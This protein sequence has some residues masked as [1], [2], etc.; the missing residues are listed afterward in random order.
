MVY[1][2]GL[3]NS[4]QDLFANTTR[5]I[6]EFVAREYEN[7][8]DFRLGIIEM[9]LPALATPTAPADKNDLLEMEL[10]KNAVKEYSAETNHRKRLQKRVFPLILGQCS[11][12][13]RDRLEA[14]KTWAKLNADSD[15]FGL[16]ALIRSS[17]NQRATNRNALHTYVDAEFELISFRQTDNMSVSDYKLKL[18]SLVEIYES[19]GGEPGCSDARL[20]AHLPTR[21][22]GAYDLDQATDAELA[23]AKTSAR[24][25]Y[26]AMLLI[27]RSDSR[28]FGRLVADMHNAHL[29]GDHSSYPTSLDQAFD[30]LVNY[31]P[32][33]QPRHHRH[34]ESGLTFGQFDDSPDDDRKPPPRGPGRGP[35]GRGNGGRGGRNPGRGRGG[36]GRGQDEHHNHAVDNT[37]VESDSYSP[38]PPVVRS[39]DSEAEVNLAA[40]SAGRLPD[41]WLLLDSCSSV[42]LVVNPDLLTNL[43]RPGNTILV[44]CNAGAVTLD[45]QGF[46]GSYPFPV[47]YH[48]TGV[49]NIVS[50]NNV[51]KHFRVRMDNDIGNYFEL[52][53]K[54]G[55]T[56]RFEPSGKGLYHHDFGDDEN[57][58]T[59]WTMISTVEEQA[60]KYTRRALNNAA[61]ARRFQNI[62]M[63]P[64]TKMLGD[65]GIPHLRNCPI[66][67]ADLQAA[68]DIFGPNLGSLK[69]KTVRRPT[70]HVK[71]G[72][73]PVPREILALYKHVEIG[74]DIMFVNKIPF[75]LTISRGLK[76]GTVDVLSNRQVST[77]A[78][79]LKAVDRTYRRRG[80]R[81]SIFRAD[82]EFE[83]LKP[84]IPE[85]ETCGQDDHV[86]EVERF[87]RTVKDRAR[88]TYRMLPFAYV[89][90]IVLIHL[91]RNCVFWINAFPQG[92]GAAQRYSPR[93]IMTGWD[94]DYVNHVREEFGGYVQTH[95]DHNNSMN[96][97]TTGAI[98]LGPCG[99]KQGAHW[100]MSLATGQRIRRSRWTALPMPTDVVNRVSEL[101]RAQN[102][103][104]T[105]TFADRHGK[106][107][108]D[109]LD[110]LSTASDFDDDDYSVSTDSSD[111]TDDISFAPS[112]EEVT[113][114]F[115]P[116]NTS[117]DPAVAADNNRLRLFVENVENVLGDES[118]S[119]DQDSD[120]ESIS[121]SPDAAIGQSRDPPPSHRTRA[122]SAAHEAAL[123]RR[124]SR[125]AAR[126]IFSDVDDVFPDPVESAGVW[127]DQST[128]IPGVVDDAPSMEI[129]GVADKA[130]D[131]SNEE[132]DAEEDEH[133]TDEY[134]PES[135][136]VGDNPDDDVKA[137]DEASLD[138]EGFEKEFES[139][140]DEYNRIIEESKQSAVSSPSANR[141]RRSRKKR[142]NKK[143]SEE[144]FVHI[145]FEDFNHHAL[146]QTITK[147][148]PEHMIT[149][150][151]EQMTAQKGIKLF[152][153]RGEKAIM[154]ELEQLLYRKVMEGRHANTLTWAQKKAALKYL[155]F[156]KEKRCGKIKGRG[157][158]D[159]RKQRLY[160]TKDETSSPTV[161]IESLFLTSMVDARERRKVI[162]VDIPG[163]FMQADVDELIHVKLE[164]DVALLLIKI[165]PTYQQFL[166]YE[167]NRPV[168]YA[169]L[170]KAL[171]GTVQAAYLFWQNLTSFLVDKLGFKVNP[172]DP[173]VANKVVDGAQCTVVWHV[174]DL[175]VSHRDQSVLEWFIDELNRE[176][177]KEAEVTV[178]RGSTHDYLGMTITFND[179]GS[180][181][182]DMSDYIEGVLRETPKEF[183]RGI[184]QTPAASHLF[185]INPDGKRLDSDRLEQ[186]H[187]LVAKLL[188]LCKRTR[189]D[190][191]L[192][193]SFLCTRVTNADEDDWKKLGRCLNY[194]YH[195]SDLALTL[196]AD[197]LNTLQWWV[198]AS[199]AV[200]QD[201]KSH[202]G[203]SF[204]LGKG[205]PINISS[206]QKINTRSS[207]EAELVG[208]NDAMGLILWIRMFMK[209]QGIP[210]S[211]NVVFQDNQS[212]ILLEN[213]GQRSSGKRTRHMNVRYYFVTDNITRK[214]MRVVYCPT[215]EMIADFF[216]K[217]LQG[218]LF[219]K[220][221]AYIMNLNRRPDVPQECVGMDDEGIQDKNDGPSVVG[222]N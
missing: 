38:T 139:L 46:L 104:K 91:I 94:V 137:D 98:C 24:D 90:R 120:D 49:A 29:R 149:L 37:S 115:P 200:H 105:L 71:S 163:A 153:E 135:T 195:H 74:V 189:P 13:I 88:S 138:S 45:T 92:D 159:G 174:D 155:M 202:T 203:G 144:E 117:L 157:C 129:P 65:V 52:F 218:T 212:A 11:R 95:E 99:T 63:R 36:R 84:M 112:V 108:P 211:D 196:Q 160:K 85:I 182:F 81:I 222:R 30:I 220:F 64:G 126:P 50:L 47:W 2:A 197:R 158:A 154:V 185:D 210:V 219:R 124:R 7:A 89:P 183:I 119:S 113:N 180:V 4:S 69:G 48:P 184:V 14:S 125:P 59:F 198:D 130:D 34:D 60:S 215:E 73:E 221:R 17:L 131:S 206:K 75:L 15:V 55:T 44:R 177:G 56:I 148:K 166:T 146:L 101:G 23:K 43:H 134:P 136:G 193:V 32:V 132:G 199:F 128:E 190:I 217:P 145:A 19:L 66:T 118:S 31:Q 164:G 16:L 107:I 186:F 156:L 194:L 142:K 204:S 175:K 3:P 109:N 214:N 116:P 103:P 216:T 114:A 76:F 179:D 9:K 209:E 40:A 79:A 57:M 12:T 67:K 35:P 77:V 152:G 165:D 25:A 6:A 187:H 96:E 147:L 102:M 167:R 178:Q 83:E 208:V 20:T 169:E 168:I 161:T 72:I 61:A 22:S 97:R 188:Y 70:D 68:E 140:Y 207:T 100:F 82:P 106:E 80:F 53:R 1:N 5:Q 21:T 213:N 123:N 143:Y 58:N 26:L 33:Y 93:F 192:T 173:C 27:V 51:S 28:R 18:V 122:R 86:P 54:D 110:D 181:K 201:F 141:S 62:V 121:S 78:N 191:Q 87:I 176:Y 111:D 39:F 172:Y 151:T 10:F 42:D 8:G 150:I 127:N 171:Y 170:K 205:C 162:T 41:R 133:P